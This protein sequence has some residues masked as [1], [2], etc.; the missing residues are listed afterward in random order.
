MRERQVDK[1]IQPDMRYT[2]KNTLEKVADALMNSLMVGADKTTDSFGRTQDS[3][4]HHLNDH[5]KLRGAAGMT[6]HLK[7]SNNPNIKAY[8]GLFGNF[9]GKMTASLP[10]LK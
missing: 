7:S 10:D 1:E 4:G 2:A 9:F 6:N 8:G 5:N 3:F